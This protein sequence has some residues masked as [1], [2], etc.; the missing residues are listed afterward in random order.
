MMILTILILWLLIC[1]SEAAL[2]GVESSKSMRFWGSIQGRDIMILL[3]LGS[4]STF[5][6][7]TIAAQLY[8]VSSLDKPLSVKVASG[9]KIQCVS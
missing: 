2:Q 7:S 1:L 3:D 8:G 9:Q 4:Y 6:S 5:I